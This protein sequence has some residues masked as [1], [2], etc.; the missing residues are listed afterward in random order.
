[1]GEGFCAREC[2]RVASPFGVLNELACDA[3]DQS[4]LISGPITFGDLGPG[5]GTRAKVP[6]E[7]KDFVNIRLGPSAQKLNKKHAL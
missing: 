2:A 4:F 7:A 5:Q 3:G 6:E 1:M